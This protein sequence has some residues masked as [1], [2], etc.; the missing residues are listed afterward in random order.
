MSAVLLDTHVLLWWLQGGSK[1]SPAAR[2]I[3]QKPGPVLVSAASAWE[4]AIKYK[5]GR[6][7]VARTLISRF[8]SAIEEEHFVELPISIRHAIQAGLLAGSQRDPFDRMLIAQAQ[9]EAIPVISTDR[10]FD[11]FKVS[12]VW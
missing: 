1:L 3:M 4:I 7:D 5:A 2:T 11:E 10:C 8:Q 6:L 12:R 9:V